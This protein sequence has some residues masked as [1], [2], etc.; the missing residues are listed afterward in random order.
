MDVRPVVRSGRPDV[1]RKPHVARH[2]ALLAGALF[3]AACGG[4]PGAAN[5]TGGTNGAPNAPTLR[6][7]TGSL[8]DL[9]PLDVGGQSLTHQA[10]TGQEAIA[11][12]P[13]ADVEDLTEQ[14]E[15][16]RLSVDQLSLAEAG[17]IEA[18]TD[19]EGLGIL[20]V[21]VPGVLFTPGS[22][23]QTRFVSSLLGIAPNART[24]YSTL[25]NRTTTTIL[26]PTGGSTRTYVYG[27]TEVIFIV[28]GP[29]DLVEEAFS[30]L[31]LRP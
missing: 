4:A 2:A 14:L 16:L 20:A 21:R 13:N 27:P 9:L 6:P 24:G 12:L 10:G 17:D 19:E 15:R 1:A 7:V 30:K 8:A 31:A 3:L 5:P 23:P 11:L 22:G 18:A 29:E 28:R 26:D 25:A